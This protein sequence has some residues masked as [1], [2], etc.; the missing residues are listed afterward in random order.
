MTDWLKVGRTGTC[1]GLYNRSN[2]N[3][4]P[5]LILQRVMLEPKVGGP[6]EHASDIKA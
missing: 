2:A 5:P 3:R 6:S 4:W 1:W